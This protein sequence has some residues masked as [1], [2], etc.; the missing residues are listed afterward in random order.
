VPA[1]TA[2]GDSLRVIEPEHRMFRTPD[3]DVHVHVWREGSDKQQ[4]QL[5][6]RDWL[7]VNEEDRL[8]YESVTRDL[9]TRKWGFDGRLRGSYEQSWLRSCDGSK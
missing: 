9:A 6:L 7:Q 3:H 1:L 4:E 5:V 8:P 2:A